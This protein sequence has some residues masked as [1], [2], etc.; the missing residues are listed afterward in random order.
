MN[1]DIKDISTQPSLYKHGWQ[2]SRLNNSTVNVNAPKSRDVLMNNSQHRL[3]PGGRYCF[4]LCVI[5]SVMWFITFIFLL[6][7]LKTTREEIQPFLRAAT[8][9]MSDS[10]G[11]TTNMNYMSESAMHVMNNINNASEQMLPFLDHL[12]NMMNASSYA[13]SNVERLSRHP[14]MHITASVEDH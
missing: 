1:I 13:L 7:E 6:L 8:P 4:C 11:V 3:S 12:M 5:I 2:N 14:T 9:L 10:K